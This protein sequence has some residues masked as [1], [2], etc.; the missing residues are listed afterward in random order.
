MQVLRKQG[1]GPQ[2]LRSVVLLWQEL[3][4]EKR[5]AFRTPQGVDL[6]PVFLIFRPQEAALPAFTRARSTLVSSGQAKS[7]P[8]V[9]MPGLYTKLPH[10]LCNPRTL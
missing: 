1:I 7:T 4:A 3:L 2:Y 9:P 5:V 10:A 6:G 8:D